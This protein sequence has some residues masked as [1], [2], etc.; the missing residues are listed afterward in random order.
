[1]NIDGQMVRHERGA[2]GWSQQH[3]ADASGLS[4]RTIQR[5]EN[6]GTASSETV[7]A[8]QGAMDISL[9]QIDSLSERKPSSHFIDSRIGLLLLVLATSFFGAL[10]GAFLTIILLR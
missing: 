10:C 3:L 9:K 1:M 4:L 5:V 6:L 2:R 7:L 8:L